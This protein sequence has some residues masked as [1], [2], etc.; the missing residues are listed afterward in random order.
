M[1]KNWVK[2][3]KESSYK[4]S[5]KEPIGWLLK[6]DELKRAADILLQQIFVDE[7]NPKLNETSL[8]STYMLLAGFAIEN[9]AKGIYFLD[10]EAT[11][12]CR[13]VK[14]GQGHSSSKYLEAMGLLQSEE[15]MSEVEKSDK[16]LVDRLSE[17][18]TGEG[19]Y[20]IATTIQKHFK[21]I[22]KP[23]QTC[24]SFSPGDPSKIDILFKKMRTRLDP[25]NKIRAVI[26]SD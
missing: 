7:K 15:K 21:N 18:T 11:E 16:E 2:K 5:A 4:K 20:H 6:A 26:L 1:I 10:H 3:W 24:A 13:L 17:Y 25:G 14:I 12:E 19:R 22:G 23:K 8:I 9:L